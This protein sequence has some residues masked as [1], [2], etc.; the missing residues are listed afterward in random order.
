MNDFGK[1]S[2][3]IFASETP[4]REDIASVLLAAIQQ[5]G[6][7][8]IADTVS[9]DSIRQLN[10]TNKTITLNVSGVT[11]LKGENANSIRKELTKST[12]LEPGRSWKS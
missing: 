8:L 4:T 10:S 3:I 6:S 1:Y 7:D 2:V 5:S 12:G 9:P 11:L